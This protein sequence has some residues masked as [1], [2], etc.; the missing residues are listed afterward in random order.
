[1]SF[2]LA[3]LVDSSSQELGFE[4]KEFVDFP[5]DALPGRIKDFSENISYAYNSPS[6]IV[7]A[8]VISVLGMC[9]G[10]GVCLVTDDPE[11]TYGLLYLYL[12]AMPGVGKRAI[13]P[14]FEPI[15]NFVINENKKIRICVENELREE[16]SAKGREPSSEDITKKIG[17]DYATLYTSMFT[18][19][20]LAQL[21]MRNGEYVVLHSTEAAGLINAI[22]G[23][24]RQQMPLSNLL[25]HCYIG[26]SY[27][28]TYKSSQE[29]HL[30]EPRMSV[31]LL[32]TPSSMKHFLSSPEIQSDGTASRFMFSVCH[33][34]RSRRPRER[35]QL[36]EVLVNNWRDITT[37]LLQAFWR[38]ETPP[39]QVLMTDEA[40]SLRLDFDD[41]MVDL[42]NSLDPRLS[43]MGIAN[44]TSENSGRIALILHFAKYGI[45]ALGK[46]L[47]S[48]TISSA[49]EITRFFLS[50]TL[51]LIEDCID[52]DPLTDHLKEKVINYLV[53]S[54]NS[55]TV[56]NL[57][58]KGVLKKKDRH[59]LDGLIKDEI[60]VAWDSSNG[61]RPSPTIGFPGQPYIPDGIS[62]LKSIK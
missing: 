6:E 14:L 59:V 34:K 8:S 32:S 61:N 20:G 31:L 22:L 3:P 36:N 30:K 12:G 25:K 51:S 23:K 21:L 62:Y 28:E 47:E 45:T 41:E 17:K 33:E 55:E 43:E 35:R 60:I 50:R 1:M 18:E 40:L 58:V 44:R 52:E 46:P 53:E 5:F 49:I 16:F 26:D 19:E 15:N 11:P 38:K 9:L 29:A 56:R 27:F 10:R 13:K 57:C 37:S 7:A 54:G 4:E 2:N 24:G 42:S 48:E 39:K